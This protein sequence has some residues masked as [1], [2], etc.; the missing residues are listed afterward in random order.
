M[1]TNQLEF[2]ELLK[3]S[4]CRGFGLQIA[5]LTLMTFVF[6]IP[7]TWARIY[8]DINAPAINKLKVA[9]ADFHN[10]GG[11]NEHPELSRKIANIINHD[12]DLS[13]YFSPIDRQAF[14]EN[15]DEGITQETISF[16]NWSVIGAELLVKGDY[17]IIGNKIELVARLF[18]TYR[19]KQILGRRLLGSIKDY[20]WVVHRFSNEIIRRLTGRDSMFLTQLA[21]VDSSTGNKE[22][23][24]SDYDGYNSRLITSG[25]Y[26]ALSPRISPDGC[27]IIYTSY[28]DGRPKLYLKDL[29]SGYTKVL[30][31]RKGLNIGAAW[32]PDGTRVALTL[33][34][35]GNPDIYLID[36]NGKILKR[37]TSSWGIDV[38]PCFSPDGKM[39][40]FVSNR[41]GSPQIYIKDLTTGNCRRLT[42]EGRYNT[43]PCWSRLNRIVYTSMNQGSFDIFTM[44]PNG[45]EP[46]QLTEGPG[47]DEDPCWSPCGRYIVFSSNR[48]GRYHLYIMSANGQNQRRITGGEG[49]QTSPSW[50]VLGN[51]CIRWRW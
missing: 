39:M 51:R 46:K 25:S 19:G 2:K 15:K 42:F 24:L 21:Y 17:T 32:T 49:E 30:S 26:I 48:L 35:N 12:L 1:I 45:G 40:A 33:S 47:N 3:K 4:S 37:L 43:S 36:L 8:I 50:G 34:V 31:Q 29:R 11:S 16:K 13:G 6:Y 5:L 27:H 10:L 7:L 28:K 41:S 23:W 18:D 20:R 9:V 44:D 22:I 38:S 14:L